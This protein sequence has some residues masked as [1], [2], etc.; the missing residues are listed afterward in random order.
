MAYLSKQSILNVFSVIKNSTQEAD[1]SNFSSL[2]YFLATDRYIHCNNGIPCDT[3]DKEKKTIFVS[4]VKDVIELDDGKYLKSLKEKYLGGK[5]LS[6]SISSNF[7]SGSSVLDSSKTPD[8][9]YPYPSKEGQSLL[10]AI[11]KQL[12]IPEVYYS[13]LDKYLDEKE[14]FALAFWLLR[15]MNLNEIS[16]KEAREVLGV[17]YSEQ[18]VDKLLPINLPIWDETVKLLNIELVEEKAIIN[19]TDLFKADEEYDN[20]DELSRQI[21]F[22]GAPGTGKS[23]KIKN[24]TKIAENNDRVFRTTFHPDSDYSTFVGAYKPKMENGKIVYAFEPQAF[25]NAYV[26]AWKSQEAVFLII[27]EINRGNCAQIFG[28]IFQLLDRKDEES[29]YN[30]KADSALADYL[31]SMFIGEKNM[32]QKILE[33]KELKLPRNLFIWATMNT[34][35]QS[36]FPIDSAFKRRWDWE[37]VKIS[38]GKDYE[39]KKEL[40]WKVNFTFEE[41]K[42]RYSCHF[43]WWEFILKINEIIAS[44]TSSDDKKLGCFFCRARKDNNGRDIID[45]KTFVGK[46]VFYLWNDVL[47]EEKPEL[48]KVHSTKGEPSFDA[49][50]KEDE[51]GETVVDT[52]ALKDFISNIFGDDFKEM[53]VINEVA[54]KEIADNEDLTLTP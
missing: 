23:N 10:V 28:D 11:N 12:S 31:R 42:K 41:D 14:R 7:F 9:E 50:Y 30:I 54:N 45:A 43:D 52:L 33:G 44:A 53:V 4:Y 8:V 39:T 21:I 22:Y 32:P 27:E 16:I 18:L 17:Y 13:N 20:T 24:K 36:L 3:G 35:D 26:K 5:S 51:E 47:K 29:E 37:Y 25:T 15:K 19:M 34:S 2:Q 48:F 40:E 49:F 1:S 46:V 38:K 6:A